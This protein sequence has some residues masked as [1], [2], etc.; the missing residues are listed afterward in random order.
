MWDFA[1]LLASL[2]LLLT[3]AKYFVEGISAIAEALGVPPLVIGMTVVAFGTS[4]PELVVNTM[5][6]AQ[7]STDLAFGNIV[8]ACLVNV[9]VV[10]AV[11][12]LLAPLRVQSALITRELPMLSLTV[13]AVVVL[14]SD[15]F[16]DGAAGSV[17]TRAD[18]IVLLLLFGVF[19]Y[20]TT[21]GALAAPRSD[22]FLADVRDEAAEVKKRPL[23]VEIGFTLGGLAGVS[24]GADWTVA[25]AVQIARGMGVSEAVIGLTIISVGTTLPEL[26][27]CVLAARRGDSDLALGNVVGSNIFNLLCIGGL[28]SVIRPIPI[29]AGGE[30]DLLVMAFLSISVLP[31]A[32]RGRR[33]ISRTEGLFLL[34]V[35]AGFLVWRL[36]EVG[37]AQ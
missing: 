16:L 8:G 20:Y 9:G 14:G 31:L 33:V 22:P 2:A 4:T 15:R 29:P 27:T 19:L 11:T 23:W 28:V 24:F 30:V 26:A 12:A 6:A 21:R 18:G 13:A 36:G 35:Y 3:A 25:F 5:S 17:W 37:R 34:L 10:L 32:L 7:G 1:L